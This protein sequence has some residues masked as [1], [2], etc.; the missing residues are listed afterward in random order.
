[1]KVFL[2]YASEDRALAE[3][4]QL[5]L[6][7]AGHEVFFDRE[8]LPAGGD[9]H[10]KIRNSVEGS[11]LF[12]FLI[13]P[14]SVAQGSYAL[15][16]MG[17]ARSKWPS[18]KGKVLP[19]RARPTPYASIPPYLKSVTVLEPSGNVAAEVLAA[20]DRL[21]SP[22][23]AG[24]GK[25]SSGGN[26]LKWG[27]FGAAGLLA[28][29]AAVF[30]WPP[31]PADPELVKL[32]K[33]VDAANTACVSNSD[34]EHAAKVGTDLNLLLTKIKGEGG[35]SEYR[36]KIIGADKGLP[37]ELQLPENAQ[38]RKCMSAYMPG[39]FKAIGVEIAAA[40]GPEADVPNPLQLRFSYRALGDGKVST[41]DTLRVN[42]QT[43]HRIVDGER[44][45]QQ[46][47]GYYSYNT[48]YPGEG[49]RILGTLMREIRESSLGTAPAPARFCLKRPSPLVPSA[50]PHVHLDCSESASCDLHFPSPKWLEPCPLDAPKTSRAFSFMSEAHAADNPRRWSVPSAKTLEAQKERMT[51][52]GY[53]LFSIETDAFRDPSVIGVEVDVRVNGVPILEDGLVPA[54]RPV[55]NDPAKPFAH[56]FALESLDFEGA[57]AGCEAIVLSLRPRLAGGKA[58]G[59][60]L[61]ATL[62]YVAL[63]DAPRQT[64][65]LGKGT[66]NWSARYVIPAD[67]WSHEAFISSITY[68]TS[69]GEDAAAAARQQA[70]TRKRDFDALGVKHQGRPVVAVIRPPLTLSGDKLAYGLTAGVV[71]ASGQ[72]RFTFS[73]QEAN[74]I[75]DTLLAA[76]S[77]SS[78]AQ[79]LINREKYIYRVAG[80]R[81]R[82][83]TPTPPGICNHVRGM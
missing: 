28:V 38:I 15:T 58:S 25:A 80:T 71:Q 23:A 83:E 36:K 29:T 39:I 21:V 1:M 78:S 13:S 60:A 31:G 74:A 18:P 53:T 70:V 6:A 56:A 34:V 12:V 79:R 45:A 81:E 43:S 77:L 69:S 54:L 64:L 8:S 4:V 42:L 48:A 24:A 47:S 76:R 52:V 3:E 50:D 2:S 55:P 22:Q 26:N 72:V 65:A 57:Q 11:D 66:L 30:Y 67:E 27:L 62:P 16:E 32:E 49:E 82:R 9:Y 14:D 63:R 68:S 46:P 35:I 51:G 17:F 41:D 20:F 19:V 73:P 33:L 40:P 75:G 59:N 44:L 10:E 61:S 37:P 7:G 5:A